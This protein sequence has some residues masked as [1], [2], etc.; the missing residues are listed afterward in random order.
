MNSV[1]LKSTRT[2]LLLILIGQLHMLHAQDRYVLKLTDKNNSPF[3]INSPTAY[4]SARAIARRQ[5]QGIA[6][7]STDLPVNPSYLAAI[8]A[9][10]ATILNYSKWLNTVTIQTAD[11][12]VLNL[13]TALPFVM[14][15]SNVGRHAMGAVS[16]TG[17]NKFGTSQ[18][19]KAPREILS[20]STLKNSAF[21]YGPAFHQ[22]N[23]LNGDALHTAGYSGDGMMIAV[24]DA[25]FYGTDV[26]S[27]FDSLFINNQIV[28][29]WDFVLGNSNVYDYHGH[30][31]SCLSLIGANEPGVMVGT[32]PHAKFIL[33]R[34][35]DGFTENLIEEYNWAAGAEF[36][37][38]I[39]ADV[40]ST[41]LG[42]TEFD[43]PAMNHTYA[44]L[45]GNTA[46]MTIAADIAASKGI[47]VVNSA[48]N[49]GSSPWNFISVP[50]D[51]D[52]NLAIGAV[53]SMEQYVS[54]SG[55]GPTP[56]GR[57]KPDVCAQGAGTYVANGFDGTVNPG[58]GTSFSGPIIA[59]LAA[60]LWQTHPLLTNMDIVQA[61]KKSAS[62][63]NTPDSL[64]GYG[65]PDFTQASMIL[66]GIDPGVLPAEDQIYAVF[67]NPFSDVVTVQYFTT[68]SQDITVSVYDAVG[69]KIVTNTQYVSPIFMNS[70]PLTL[71][72]GNGF[73]TLEV[74]NEAGVRA[75]KHL[76]KF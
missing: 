18:P 3:S 73:Y 70:I 51:A 32:A 61:I 38:S 41:S 22:I 35:E 37:D 48:G 14:T 2:I 71:G 12:A 39:G 58:S 46:P 65:I 76:V 57:I 29:T 24:L 56:D 74:I 33:C 25:G 62:Q 50:A 30:G 55:K 36:A 66:G 19:D 6:I 67:P 5:K 40:F 21:S 49:E 44:T 17:Q 45:D 54:F 16:T 63:Y 15:Y 20:G 72:H 23:M 52:S 31:T 53:D 10:G 42:Y 13:C 75:V 64:L 8:S 9:T 27:V 47:V 43:D 7:S 59:G 68:T 11:T 60:C 26:I 28:A 69:R 4:L 34:T 1:K